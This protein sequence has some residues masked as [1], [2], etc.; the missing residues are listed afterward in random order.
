MQ[1]NDDRLS[2][3]FKRNVQLKKNWNIDQKNLH[4]LETKDFFK[5][6]QGNCFLWVTYADRTRLG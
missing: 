1:A 5:L 4:I 6:K 3:R 2:E